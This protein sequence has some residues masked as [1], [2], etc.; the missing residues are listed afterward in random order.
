MDRSN[1]VRSLA[2][3]HPDVLIPHLKQLFAQLSSGSPENVTGT[4]RCILEIVADQLDVVSIDDVIV[5]GI[6]P[7]DSSGELHGLY[8]RANLRPGR[9]TTRVVVWMRTAARGQIV[10]P[11]TFIRT[12]LHELT[13]HLDY[14]LLE[15]GGSRHTDGFYA[16]ESSLLQQVLPKHLEAD[17]SERRQLALAL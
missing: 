15:L 13:H 1:A 4:S 10:A 11:R 14:E 5:L 8:E 17:I 3:P 6:R 7:A 2:V 12:L 16:R 9:T